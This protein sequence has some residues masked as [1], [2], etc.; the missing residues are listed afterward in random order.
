MENMKKNDIV[1][2][3]F[4]SLSTKNAPKDGC[5][6]LS[7]LSKLTLNYMYITKNIMSKYHI[8]YYIK[9]KKSGMPGPRMSNSATSD[10][11]VNFSSGLGIGR[12]QQGQNSPSDECFMRVDLFV[13]LALRCLQAASQ[14]G[15]IFLRKSMM[16]FISLEGFFG[17]V[18]RRSWSGMMS[19]NSIN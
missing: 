17:T 3:Y 10:H 7:I 13:M 18:S 12:W 16:E 9:Q 19:N 8:I 4:S 15:G 11:K 1:L 6:L 14:S 5:G 2:I